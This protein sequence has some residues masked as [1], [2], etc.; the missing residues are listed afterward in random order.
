[1]SG[2]LARLVARWW[3]LTLALWAVAL[4]LAALVAPPFEDVAT[5]DDAA[6]LPEDSRAAIGNDLLEEGWPDDNFTRAAVIAAVRSDAPL[7]DDDEAAPAVRGALLAVGSVDGDVS[8]D[9]LVARVRGALRPGAD[10]ALAVRF[11]GGVLRAAP[12]LLLH[13]PELF[14]AVDGAIRDLSP[15]AF[16]AVLPDLRRGFTWLRPTETHRL[17]GRVAERT[18]SRAAD[19]DV[20]VR[21][22]ENDLAAGLA[23]ERELAAVLARDGLAHWSGGQP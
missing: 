18:G 1:V 15:D 14:D 5:F 11:L 20:R 22:D 4:A 2:R 6:F 8:D 21:V 23:V 13:T 7:R 3:W 16:L 9:V 17:A 10:P 12:D 19:V